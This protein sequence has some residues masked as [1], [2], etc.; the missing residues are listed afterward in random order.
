MND[1]TKQLPEQSDTGTSYKRAVLKTPRSGTIDLF[2]FE[3]DERAP[4]GW[5]LMCLT[6]SGEHYTEVVGRRQGNYWTMAPGE[7]VYGPVV[8]WRYLAEGEGP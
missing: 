4:E 5:W 6:H 2:A 3:W 7:H 8:A 1:T